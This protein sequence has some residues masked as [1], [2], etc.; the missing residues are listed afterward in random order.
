[1]SIWFSHEREERTEIADED[2]DLF[3]LG[4]ALGPLPYV[5][6]RV[7]RHVRRAVLP[8]CPAI[9]EAEFAR[10]TFVV[11]RAADGVQLAT[12]TRLRCLELLRERARI[13]ELSQAQ[14]VSL[15]EYLYE[16]VPEHLSPLLVVEFEL[17]RD[18]LVLPPDDLHAAVERRL[19]HVVASSLVEGRDG[20]IEWAAA[21][22]ARLP[23]ECM[24]GESAWV[25][26]Q[27]AAARELSIDQLP[28][29]AEMS[30]EGLTQL[31]SHGLPTTVIGLH[32]SPG[33]IEFGQ[34]SSRR[35]VGVTVLDT[36]P[37]VVRL[38]EPGCRPV[39]LRIERGKTKRVEWPS[40]NSCVLES[41]TG[42]TYTLGDLVGDK[43]PE[44]LAADRAIADVISAQRAG[45]AVP[46]TVHKGVDAGYVVHLDD[47][48]ATALATSPDAVLHRGDK[49]H[50]KIE[51]VSLDRRWVAASV[52]GRV[53]PDLQRPGESVAYVPRQNMPDGVRSDA[54][55]AARLIS[56]GD[57]RGRRRS[58]HVMV[59]PASALGGLA[60]N[61]RP[62]FLRFHRAVH[63]VGED[64]LPPVGADM[65][66][67]VAG[68]IGGRWEMRL[69][70]GRASDGVRIDYSFMGSVVSAI[71]TNVS[72]QGAELR[73]ADMI[74]IWLPR[75]EM[76]PIPARNVSPKISAGSML[77]VRVLGID[78][79]RGIYRGSQRA[80]APPNLFQLRAGRI[81]YGTVAEI[82]PDGRTW[83]MIDPV[84]EL[85]GDPFPARVVD[86]DGSSW[87]IGTRVVVSVKRV[88]RSSWTLLVEPHEPS[89]NV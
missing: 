62:G 5:P 14:I 20:I 74:Q 50:V 86:S 78:E 49:L 43:S 3:S 70:L 11:S 77:D 44:V 80:A 28:L 88:V 2:D 52:A 17:L 59:D 39:E 56:H 10:S 83:I 76:T 65:V 35:R 31:R 1:M 33:I 9:V 75:N 18:Y 15:H 61:H 34:P 73:T 36:N 29:P 13:G 87:Q 85:S 8:G 41:I 82:G 89:P 12:D 60:Y 69:G 58:A 32:R 68:L 26:A 4:L 27:L 25:L 21:A 16:S 66:V 22:Q 47:I 64:W 71:V 54:R 42:Q 57:P 81:L 7:L 67:H 63:F 38:H 51:H 55:F 79:Q 30:W 19:R 24:M 84:D 23:A 45:R 40:N 48:G 37:R 72:F 53:N 6:Y 46:A